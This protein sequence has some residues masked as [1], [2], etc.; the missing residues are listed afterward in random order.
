MEGM[1]PPSVRSRRELKRLL[2]QRAIKEG[3]GREVILLI[4]WRQAVIRDQV[5]DD[6]KGLER[7]LTESGA[8]PRTVRMLNLLSKALGSDQRYTAYAAASPGT[9]H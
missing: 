8:E 2:L 3:R 9:F 6:I 5:Q 7:F 4:Q 1:D